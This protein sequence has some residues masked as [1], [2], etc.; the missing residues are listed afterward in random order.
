MSCAL[1]AAADHRVEP[2]V[3]PCGPFGGGEPL[4][5]LRVLDHDAA[6]G[7]QIR[8]PAAAAGFLP[9]AQKGTQRAAAAAALFGLV[10]EQPPDPAALPEVV[11]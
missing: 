10:G 6:G 9:S 8:Q 7:P 3:R 5:E 11:E 4:R 2:L 1:S